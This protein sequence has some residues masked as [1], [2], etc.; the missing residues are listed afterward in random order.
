MTDVITRDEAIRNAGQILAK[1]RAQRDA[2]TPRQAAEDAW[3]PGHSLGSVEAIEALIIRQRHDALDQAPAAGVDR[4]DSP[5]AQS[6][7]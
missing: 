2:K 3:Y 6:A 7:A 1:I 4:T 5:S